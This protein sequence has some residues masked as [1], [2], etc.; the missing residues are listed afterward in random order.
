MAHSRK[1]PRTR[2]RKAL[3]ATMAVARRNVL[4]TVSPEA[5]GGAPELELVAK[6]VALPP[7]VFRTLGI[8]I[9]EKVYES[10]S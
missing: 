9:L 5:A 7:L 4:C 3:A 8:S 1:K 2:L 10:V 6:L